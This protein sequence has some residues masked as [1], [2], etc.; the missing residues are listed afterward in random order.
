MAEQ[1]T[2]PDEEASLDGGAYDI[3]RGRLE[4]QARG[5]REAAARLN[6]RRVEVFGGTELAL[7]GNER[8]RTEHNCV[9][10]DIIEVAGLLL[11]GYRIFLGLKREHRLEDVFSVHR[12]LK[13]GDGFKFEPVPTEEVPW[14][15]EPR[16]VKDFSELFQYYKDARLTQLMKTE[17]GQL[18]AVFRVGEGPRDVKVLRWAIEPEGV[19]HYVDNRGEDDFRYPPRYDFQWTE[20]GRDDF[21]RGRHPHV[22]VL[23]TVFVETVGGDLTVKVEDNTEDGRGI[24]AEPVEN[25]DQSLDDASIHYAKLG[26]L[27]LLKVRPYREE[28]WRH[29]VFNTRTNDV[30]RIDAI[31]TSCV[32]LPEDHGIIFPGGYYLQDGDRKTFDGDTRGMQL[33]RIVK[34]PNG[35]D[36]AYVFYQPEQGRNVVL[37]Y[38]L[39]DKEVQSPILGHGACMFEDGHMVV[40]RAE[41][42]PS[43]VHQMRIYATPFMS[44]EHAAE[45]TH[46]SEHQGTLYVRLG[47]AELVRGISDVGT[48][49]RQVAGQTPTMR[50][51]EDLVATCTRVADSYPWL[52]DEQAEGLGAH[53]KEVLATAELVIDEFEKVLT[54][55]RSAEV[56][57]GE[58]DAAQARLFTDIRPDTWRTVDHFVDAM[59]RLRKQRGHLITLKDMRYV[60][61]ARVEALEAQV[62]AQFDE[63]S[64]RAVGF[65]ETDDALAP[66]QAA[67]AAVLEKI[68]AVAFTPEAAP[69]AEEV[70]RLATGLDLLTE[71]VAGLKIEDPNARTRILEE[72]GEVF[73]GV[74]RA[75]A[76]LVQRRRELQKQ[77]GTAQ[78]GAQ[79]RLLTQSVQSALG[80]CDTP[81]RCDEQLTRLLVMLEE[82]EGRFG[83][84]DEFLSDLA[85]K[86]EEI[87]EAFSGKKQQLLE[88]RQRRAQNVVAAAERILQGVRRR[89]LGLKELDELNAYFAGDSMVLKVRDL[90]AELVSLGD[91]VKADELLSRIKATRDEAARQLRDKTELFEG[92]DNVIRLGKHRF[93]VNTQPLEL[94]VL[95]KDGGLWLNLGGTDYQER[96]TD[97]RLAQLA[98]YWQQA[99]VSETR[100]V[101][102]AEYL[103]TSI[104]FAAEE[105]GAKVG[106]A[107]LHE[108]AREEGGLLALV[109]AEVQGR[110]DEGYERGVHDHDAAVLLEKLLGMYATA[111]LLRFPPRARA[112]AC[113]YW[114]HTPAGEHKERLAR[115]ARSLSRLE[116]SLGASEEAAALAAALGVEVTAFC[117]ERGVPCAAADALTA[118]RYL[119]QELAADHPRFAT[120]AEAERLKDTFLR[121]L[122]NHHHRAPF[123]E[124][125]RALT[126][127]LGEAFALARAWLSA[128]VTRAAA[129]EVRA[130][131]PSLDEA[132]ALLLT[133]GKLDRDVSA[134]LLAAD[135]YGLLGNH[136]RLEGQRM[137]LRLDELLVRIEHHRREVVPAFQHYR[138]LRHDVLE[139]ARARMRLDELRPRVLSSFVRNKLINDVYLPFIGDNLAKQMGAVGDSKRTDLMGL[140]LLVSPPGY[141]KTTLMEYVASRLGLVFVKVNGPSLGHDVTSLDPAEAPNATARLE[142]EK[143]NFAFE[144]GNNV[145]LYLDDIQHTHT[146]LLQ[147]FISLC[148]GSRRV[149]GVWRGR[150]R[151][152]DMR[153]K[154]IAV[155]M[156]GNPYTETGEKFQIPDMLANRADTYNLGEILGGR[157][158]AFALSYLENALTSNPVLA[159]LATREQSD[160]YLF[161]RMA[162]GE[163]IN[164]NDLKHNYSA[165]EVQE[166]VA[167][168]KKLMVC[169]D[170]LLKVNAEYIRSAS[171]DDRYRT[172][173]PFKLQGSYRNMSKLAEKVAA[174]MN[175][176]ELQRLLSDHYQSEAQTLTAGAE[177]NLLKLAELRGRMSEEQHERWDGI[178]RS[179]Q[180]NQL[181]GGDEDDPVLKVTNTL[182][183]VAQ[184]LEQIGGA[185]ERAAHEAA[186]AR[187]ADKES[188][189]L[190]DKALAGELQALRKALE[191][192][193]KRAREAAAQSHEA[194]GQS[195]QSA[196]TTLREGLSGLGQAAKAAADE[197]AK[198]VAQSA[199]E[200]DGRLLAF[201][202]RLDEGLGALAGA[203]V[204]VNVTAPPF[205]GLA[206]A[207]VAQQRLVE[208]SLLPLLKGLAELKA[209]PAPA[210]APAAPPVAPEAARAVPEPVVVGPVRTTPPPR[211]GKAAASPP[212]SVDLGGVPTQIQEAL[213]ILRQLKEMADAAP[214]TSARSYQPWTR[215]PV[216]TRVDDKK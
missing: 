169:R 195:A 145:M 142:V 117:A 52:H 25:K 46:Q 85:E 119:A 31:G 170:L 75:R 209:A 106:L 123:E 194:Q 175:D 101:Y 53:L 116:Q 19:V 187:A 8:I 182:A 99:L 164:T 111:G 140:L 40:F 97:E 211:K 128:F 68:E 180:R 35:E 9:P 149:E 157:Q 15:S 147:K 121:A 148:D 5:L 81:E 197:N 152:Y 154:K 203:R 174:V 10:R 192:A 120:S 92:D 4:E 146:E 153:G 212:V 191:Q 176:D 160:V 20:T 156:A 32:Q 155:V 71:V 138:Q 189:E 162:E 34:S 39:I 70:D 47:N 216:G 150:T 94:T 198:A 22:N 163:E 12:L 84:L 109:R 69:L 66:Y 2:A 188:D 179:F 13:E 45:L 60:D 201:L 65:L 183:A 125:L 139:E 27:I 88:E 72:I 204:D 196:L 131:A 122:D 77:E 26:S 112:L 168:I 114:G 136:P 100:E 172:E 104:L 17:A 173:P 42:E 54:I 165:V 73:G 118:G 135:V 103:A 49:V 50:V 62:A 33:L 18:L 29:L 11:F 41:D 107:A 141:G 61:K 181:A 210:P 91:S 208:G 80:L 57:L 58:A 90:A 184:R 1:K 200:A 206:D 51:Y 37:A 14:L 193:A 137:A 44:D 43:R 124:D 38:N 76:A 98:P 166:I 7:I 30:A 79:F 78:F 93:S 134:A 59:A 126:G 127:E 95:S 115:R 36:V 24:Y 96:L 23:D 102:R 87:Y 110:Y 171:M 158:D 83:E 199:R 55:K 190:E 133:E 64:G 16:F 213:D 67:Q 214:P 89:S 6:A 56:A 167:V 151:T 159:P 48:V 28:E 3:I 202:K 144:M 105:P 74:N 185:V 132:V 205:P 63:L 177:Q 130:L 143:I 161:S 113:L 86:R 207:V 82:L 178:K 215:K 108:A 21:V 129:E 186:R